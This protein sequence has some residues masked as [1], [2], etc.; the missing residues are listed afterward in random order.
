MD[1]CVRLGRA[2]PRPQA[3]RL[4]PALAGARAASSQRGP[5]WWAL[6]QS[7][8]TELCFNRLGLARPGVVF[9]YRHGQH[10]NGT[11][12][13]LL[14]PR[15]AKRSPKKLQYFVRT[16]VLPTVLAK[17]RGVVEKV[18]KARDQEAAQHA[19]KGQAAERRDHR[20]HAP[21]ILYRRRPLPVAQATCNLLLA[22]GTEKNARQE[23]QAR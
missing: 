6:A 23:Q 20:E 9:T 14:A 15:A 11:W 4:L 8:K 2:R 5:L 21:R 17:V 12:W 19:A 7:Q 10:H 1:L 22:P 16:D 18:G 13:R 3:T